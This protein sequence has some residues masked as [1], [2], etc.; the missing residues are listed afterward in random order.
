MKELS[1]VI[2]VDKDNCVN[3]H[4]CIDACPVKHCNDGSGD[5]VKLNHNTCIGCG[6]C[7]KACTHDARY[8]IDD[9]EH[10]LDDVKHGERIV[11]IAAPS[12]ASSFPNKYLNLN[13]W[14][15]SIGVDA[16]FDVSF[17]AELTVKSYL[18]HV[19]ANNPKM[20]IAQP[21]PALVTYIEMYRPELL[22]YLAP[23][24]SPMLHTIKMIKRFYP[25]YSRHK[26][27]VL[28]PCV[29]KKREFDETGYGDY[30]VTYHNLNKYFDHNNIR[31]DQFPKVDYDNPDAE[32]AVL[33]S[34]PGGLLRTAER[35]YP[36][37]SEVSRKI[38]GPE[39]I[40]K[41]FNGLPSA[42]NSGRNPLLVD[43]LNCEMGCNGGTG[44]DCKEMHV[45][46]IESLV[47]E[48]SKQVRGRYGKKGLINPKNSVK[49][50][51]KYIDDHWEKGLYDRNYV[52]L[53]SNV[54]IKMPTQS[55]I[56][57]I[58]S[59]DLQKESEKEVYNCGACGYGSC[60]G[61]AVAIYNGRN[62]AENCLHYNEK[63]ISKD[64]EKIARANEK[65]SKL[66]SE[67]GETIGKANEM[68]V[69]KATDLLNM[70]QTQEAEFENLVKETS[71]TSKVAE[72]FVPIVETINDITDQTSL[73]ALNA[74]IEAARAGDVGRGFAVVADEVKKLSS[75]S[76][77]ET[78]KIKPYSEEI[79]AAFNMINEKVSG[80]SK[81]YADT[82]HLIEEV[83]AITEEISAQTK[84]LCTE[85]DCN[86]PD[87]SEEN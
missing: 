7:L 20:V 34:S 85:A 51:R 69:K 83:T 3:C 50:L 19:K 55:D 8:V 60:E 32:R 28:S 9:I 77:A 82:A 59:E 35:E 71:E 17:G 22:P 47:E 27:L 38:E 39:L 4:A 5:T 48:R 65:N 87:T 13:G 43:C 84:K 23:A 40:Y 10:F 66:A 52:D 46:E 74:A 79:Q 58:Y 31:L 24:D 33:F 49:E 68:L 1:P 45:D 26:V 2:G 54:S 78:E 25:D 57:K 12:V 44:T 72:K 61:M 29:A 62:K 67:I 14:L 64:R 86:R 81:K 21:C 15:K 80:T 73:L 56:Q 70:A 42:V 6:E 11:A 30:N 37:I 41:Y 53:S 16:V 18:E 75:R 76:M 63:V 36:G